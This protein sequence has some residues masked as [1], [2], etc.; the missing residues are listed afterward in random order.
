MLMRS[1]SL[2]MPTF[3]S[4]AVPSRTTRVIRALVKDGRTLWRIPLLRSICVITRAI[5]KRYASI[6][7]FP[8]SHCGLEKYV[9]ESQRGE[10]GRCENEEELRRNRRGYGSL[11]KA[12]HEAP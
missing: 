11:C 1:L 6:V 5:S 7:L 10:H 12:W 9:F 2:W 3:A 8:E 4:D